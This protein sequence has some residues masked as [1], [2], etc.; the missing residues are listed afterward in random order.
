MPCP[1]AEPLYF[2]SDA[3]PLFGWLHRSPPE[4]GGALGLLLCNPFGFEE[5]CAHRSLRHLAQAAAAAGV[6]A[7]RFDYPGCGNSAGTDREPGRLAAWVASVH[8]AV[9]ALRAATGVSRVALFGIRL[10]AALAALAAS[11]RDDIAGLIAWAP[12]LSGRAYLRELRLLGETLDSSGRPMPVDPALFESAGFGLAPD[13]VAAIEAID[14]RRLPRRPAPRVL[15]VPRDDLPGGADWRAALEQAGA[16]VTEAAWPGYAA[17]MTDPQRAELPQR[18]I[19]GT[20]DTLRDWRG[21]AAPAPTR[22]LGRPSVGLAQPAGALRET[23][24]GID[25]GGTRLFGVLSTPAEGVARCGVLM[26]NSGSVHHIGPNRLWVEL[27]RDWAARGIAVLRLDLSGLGDSPPWP[28]AAENIVYSPHAASDIAAAIAWLRALPGI[29][30]CRLLGLCSG[31]Y[32]AFKAAVAGQPIERCVAVNPLTFFWDPR[33]VVN[34]GLRDYEPLDALVRYRRLA[35]SGR[36]WRRLLAG[37]L[38]LPA[39]GRMLRR[40]T[41]LLARGMATA[42]ARGIGLPLREDLVRE[43]ARACDRPRRLHF[44]FSNGDPGLT[45]LR[46]QGGRAV[47]Q[48]LDSGRLTLA[49]IDGADHTFTRRAGRAQLVR[50][51]DSLMGLDTPP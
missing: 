4:V 42:L 43:L 11:E 19:T 34:E 51:L 40:R 27:A 18:L 49:L 14:L 2:G 29:E 46:L 9:E 6:P 5:V 35:L 23:V 48:L 31:A 16:A 13:A 1:D 7:L 45:L 20:L 25:A 21:D 36:S 22:P 3:T 37:E 28:G 32:H 33:W 15:L 50:Q 44:V 8:T 26:L 10:G 38:D 24:V 12:V 17:L 39:I 41:T 30:D 47:R